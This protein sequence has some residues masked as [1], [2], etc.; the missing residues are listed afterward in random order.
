MAEKANKYFTLLCNNKDLDINP[1]IYVNYANVLDVLGRTFES[2]LI[3]DKA[4]QLN[5]SHEMA[6]GN[7]AIAIKSFAD[8]SGQYKTSIYIKSYQL[9]NEALLHSRNI[10][11]IGGIPAL[12]QFKDEML[13]IENKFLRISHVYLETYLMQ[14]L[15]YL[16]YQN[17]KDFILIIAKKKIYFLMYIY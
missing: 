8:I 12:K 4:I 3:Y 14:V 13:N 7:K 1:E 5:P 2:I 6:I 9:L 16:N 10:I 11:R 15:T 17:L